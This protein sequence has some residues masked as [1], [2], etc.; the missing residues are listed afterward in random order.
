MRRKAIQFKERRDTGISQPKS[1]YRTSEIR[2]W[3]V[4]IQVEE[5]GGAGTGQ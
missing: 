3:G 4:E 1:R 2:Y 5:R